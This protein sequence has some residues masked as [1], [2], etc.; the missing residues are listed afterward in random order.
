[1]RVDAFVGLIVLAALLSPAIVLLALRRWGGLAALRR[2]EWLLLYALGALMC[3]AVLPRKHIEGA[4]LMCWPGQQWAYHL[5]QADNEWWEQIGKLAAIALALLLARGLRPLLTHRRSALALGYW[6]G[7][8]Y[9]IGE[10]L[11]LSALFTWPQWG[12]LFGVQTFT[13][14]M[15]GWPYVW[16]RLWAMHMHAVMGALIGLGLFGLAGL[17]SKLRFALFFTLAM[18]YHHLVDGTI[19][20]AAFVPAVAR[21]AQQMGEW[22]VPALT[23]LGWL[24]LGLAAALAGNRPERSV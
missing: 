22:F 20:V 1:M 17:G 21:A 24:L 6:T 2:R 4:I 5:A 19:I 13:P 9:G 12:R 11:L 8:C 3:A 18:A 15:I 16:E 10:A 23:A 14:Y 7:L